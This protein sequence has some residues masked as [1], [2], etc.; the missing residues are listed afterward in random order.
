MRFR[1]ILLSFAAAVSSLTLFPGCSSNPQSETAA[2]NLQDTA[3]ATL[4]KFEDADRSLPNVLDSAPGYAVFPSVG[5]AG[6][7]VGGAYG[8]GVVYNQNNKVV[9][10]ADIK[11][12]SIG[13]Q[14]GGEDYNELIVFRDPAAL[15]RFKNGTYS[16]SA[17]ASA[18]AI[19][20]GA[21]AQADF[22]Q[23]VAVFTMTNSGLMAEAAVAGQKFGYTPSDEVANEPR[24]TNTQTTT[25][26]ETRTET[27]ETT[28]PPAPA[29]QP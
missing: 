8:K 22:K 17:E 15:E 29:P 13:F 7:I 25:S 19:K 16:L 4:N 1:N 9:G 23:G 27:H 20:A 28:P 2:V 21:A 6:F 26:T 12:A 5:K 18:V 11:Q 24:D 3:R 14:A 10:Y